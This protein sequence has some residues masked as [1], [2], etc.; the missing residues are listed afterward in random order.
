LNEWKLYRRKGVVEARPFDPTE[1]LDG[2]SVS[3]VDLPTRGG[4]I[5]R[6]PANHKDMWYVAPEFF[7][8]HF[9]VV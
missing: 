3:G 6:N 7:A 4:M 8:K 1:P 5:C 2:I 9:E